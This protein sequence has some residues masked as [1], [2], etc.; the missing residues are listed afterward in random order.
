MN[1]T[2]RMATRPRE[3]YE[4]IRRSAAR[5]FAG[6]EADLPIGH[7][8]QEMRVPAGTRCRL[9]ARKLTFTA[10][11]YVGRGVQFTFFGLRNQ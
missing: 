4:T 5:I 2:R 6:P 7:R 1:C 11:P 10:S 9:V 8:Q 3:Q